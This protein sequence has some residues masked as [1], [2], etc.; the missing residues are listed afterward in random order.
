MNIVSETVFSN[1]SDLLPSDGN[2]ENAS[3]VAEL[4]SLPLSEDVKL[5][6]KVSQNMHADNYLSLIAAHGGEQEL[7]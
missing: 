5:T 1:A 2:Y 6:L 4:V 3:K 7:V